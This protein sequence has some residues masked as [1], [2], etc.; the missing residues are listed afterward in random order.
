MNGHGKSDRPVIPAKPS[1]K[2]GPSAAEGVEGRGLTKGNPRQHN[3]PRTLRRT[4][5]YSA[6]ERVRHAARRDRK[7]RFT[8]LA[9]LPLNDPKAC[10]TE[11]DRAMTQ[12]GFKGVMLFSNVNGTAL[13]DKAYWPMYEKANELGAVLYIHPIHPV[14]V[15]AMTDYWLMPL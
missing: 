2:A 5:V 15:E 4:R 1:N 11:L 13:S 14:G 12:L 6:L 7:K 10:V 9:T 8:A 3:A